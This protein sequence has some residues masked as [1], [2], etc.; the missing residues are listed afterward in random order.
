MITVYTCLSRGA[1]GVPAVERMALHSGLDSL[2]YVRDGFAISDPRR[3]PGAFPFPVVF[4]YV[5][6][7]GAPLYP[8]DRW[9]RACRCPALDTPT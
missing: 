5:G 6:S 9:I 7:N 3:H 8:D 1:V 2:P 4:R